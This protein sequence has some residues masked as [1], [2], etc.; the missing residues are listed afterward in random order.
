MSDLHTLAATLRRVAQVDMKPKDLIAAVRQ[1]H[2]E[3]TKKQIVRAAFY[4]LT[5][6]ASQ[7]APHDGQQAQQ[8]H[9][10][11]LTEQASDDEEPVPERVRKKGKRK[12]A[13][14]PTQESRS[15]PLG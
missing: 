15:A 4:A 9:A 14:S 2:P 11:A 6:E 3:A 7:D 13:P 5:Q 10:F 8:L 1:R 12:T